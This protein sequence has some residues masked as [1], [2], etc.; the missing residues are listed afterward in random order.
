L[1][2]LGPERLE[3]LLTFYLKLHRESL[4]PH[5]K[6]SMAYNMLMLWWDQVFT[7]DNTEISVADCWTDWEL[8]GLFWKSGPIIMGCIR[9]RKQHTRHNTPHTTTPLPVVVCNVWCVCGV[10]W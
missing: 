8:T 4:C 3:R 2:R 5:A 6:V 9:R 1:A 7:L 10:L